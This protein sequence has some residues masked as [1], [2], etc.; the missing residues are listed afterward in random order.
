MWKGR[1]PRHILEMTQESFARRSKSQ[2]HRPPSSSLVNCG[3]GTNPLGVPPAVRELLGS[4]GDWN[5][6]DY[7]PPVAKDLT[8]AVAHYLGD[9]GLA[10]RIVLGQGSMDVLVTLTRLLLPPGSLLSGVSPQF[11]DMPLQAMQ[12]SVRYHPVLL[13]GPRFETDLETWMRAARLRPHVLF[14]DRPHNPTGQVLPLRDLET[15][16]AECLGRGCWVIV[17]EAYGDYLPLE[18]SAVAVK[19]PNCIVT[20]SFSKAWGLAG[21]RIGYA[22]IGDPE[23]L[24]IYQLLQRPF[25]V[26]LP[27][28]RTAMAALGDPEFLERTKSY[29][30]SAKAAM[31]DALAGGKDMEVAVTHPSTP[32]MMAR[33]RRGNL[34][35]I[36]ARLGIDSEP[37]SA[38]LDLDDSAVRL[39]VPPPED[40]ERAVEF[41]SGL[42]D[43]S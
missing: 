10:D 12:G 2:L 1:L 3:L 42:S 17:D 35:E 25:G 13:K 9:K 18:E 19:H 27:G 15:V 40:L 31:M 20:R 34:F 37:G 32:I 7:P 26:S 43:L 14:I 8:A 28:I 39:R 36:L 16:V 6:C 21:M 30:K 22:V 29:V 5:I 41:L 11:T 33:R 24:Q 4:C 23:L 38:Y